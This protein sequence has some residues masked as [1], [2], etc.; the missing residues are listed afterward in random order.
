MPLCAR[1]NFL[2][3]PVPDR[4]KVSVTE[5]ESVIR[6]SLGF[7]MTVLLK[8]DIPGSST[9]CNAEGGFASALFRVAW[10]AIL[11]GFSMEALLL[12]LAAG[13]GP[14]PGLKQIAADL[15]K[16]VFLVYHRLRRARYRYCRL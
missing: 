16:Q 15:V 13:F 12:L 11:L 2:Y 6:K 14:S 1:T 7:L 3:R 4:D 5:H 10:L 9:T 8:Q